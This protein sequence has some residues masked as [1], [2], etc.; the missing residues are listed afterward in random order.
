MVKRKQEKFLQPCISQG[1]TGYLSQSAKKV[2]FYRKKILSNVSNQ[3]SENV[4]ALKKISI[5]E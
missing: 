4:C 5:C 1:S 3:K 2:L